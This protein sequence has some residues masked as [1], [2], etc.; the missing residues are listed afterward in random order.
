MK[1]WSD[2][3]LCAF[4]HV[5]L[6]HTDAAPCSPLRPPAVSPSV[7]PVSPLPRASPPRRPSLARQRYGLARCE[8]MPCRHLFA[9]SNAIESSFDSPVAPPIELFCLLTPTSSLAS[10]PSFYTLMICSGSG[11]GCGAKRRAGSPCEAGGKVARWEDSIA[12]LEAVAAGAGG[13]RG[14]R[15]VLAGRGR[16]EASLSPEVVRRLVRGSRHHSRGERQVLP[17]IG[18]SRRPRLLRRP[19]RR[20]LRLQALLPRKTTQDDEPVRAQACAL[21]PD[22]GPLAAAIRAGLQHAQGHRKGDGARERRRDA[23]APGGQRA[24]ARIRRGRAM[25]AAGCQ[26]SRRGSSYAL[27]RASRARPGL[28]VRR[29]GAAHHR[30]GLGAEPVV[31]FGAR[32]PGG[33]VAGRLGLERGQ[34]RA[35]AGAHE[36]VVGA[37]AGRARAALSACDSGPG[38]LAGRAS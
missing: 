19:R 33:R 25:R 35:V 37:R 10:T 16:G 7:D 24:D 11:G 34:L 9:F 13:G 17:R 31:P 1:M 26:G 23:R 4:V 27:S 3:Q 38:R 21:P 12:R 15:R 8:A 30:L 2:F 18:G 32:S 20:P 22:R 6:T 14:R 5:H 28:R 29:R 36:L